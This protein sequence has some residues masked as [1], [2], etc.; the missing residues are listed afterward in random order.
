MVFMKQCQSFFYQKSKTDFLSLLLAS[1]QHDLNSI[2]THPFNMEL[3]SGS[4]KPDIFGRYLR[5]DFY[6]LQRFSF[7]LNNL[8]GRILPLYPELAKQLS[9]LA[10]DI[11][12]NEQNMQQQYSEHLDNIELH[13]PGRT[14]K[15][16][17]DYL[18]EPISEYDALVELI[19]YY[20]CFYVYAELGLKLE[21]YCSLEDNPYK[22]WILTY[23][24][25][26]FVNATHEFAKTIN[27]AAAL[28]SESLRFKMNDAYKCS[29][30]FERKFIHS[31]YYD[32]DP[33]AR[34]LKSP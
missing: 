13:I 7:G 6:Y 28:A 34:L 27:Q 5:D 2:Y 17:A 16:Y 19:K 23:A 4:L 22:K 21:E 15:D 20:P 29:V 32:I 1:N 18:N 31:I 24:S 11:V 26:D 25:P 3:F 12:D 33:E 8:S 14:I 9:F 10:N 30:Q